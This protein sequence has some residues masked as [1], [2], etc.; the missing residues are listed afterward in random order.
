[1]AIH[2]PLLV[3]KP[4]PV[5]SGTADFE[6]KRGAILDNFAKCV[7]QEYR[8]APSYILEPRRDV[9]GIPRECGILD[10]VELEITEQ[11]D[12]TGLAEAIAANKY[13]AVQVTTAFLKR[14]IVAHQVSCCL[15]QWF[16]DE[17]LKRA[18]ELDEYLAREGRTVGPL[19]GVPIS[20]KQHIPLAN[21]WSDIGFF[22]TRHFDESDSVLVSLLRN[23]GAVFY[24]K[25]NR[26]H[27]R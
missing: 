12:A 27:T 14:S 22:S 1:M 10:D 7:P 15:T 6:K 25:T 2:E 9:T 13:S 5:P 17:A 11:Y 3:N 4:V 23:L 20:I 26:K 8:I 24:C 21:A 18:Q 16:P 19:H